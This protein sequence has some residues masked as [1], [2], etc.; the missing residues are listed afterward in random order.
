MDNPVKFLSEA[1]DGIQRGIDLSDSI[2]NNDMRE[3]LIAVKRQQLKAEDEVN[4]LMGENA[5]LKDQNIQL[6][7]ENGRYRVDTPIYD[8]DEG[9]VTKIER[10]EEGNTTI[11]REGV[12]CPKCISGETRRIIDLSP[13][14]I[15]RHR[16]G[17][18]C[19]S[20]GFMS[21]SAYETQAKAD[22]DQHQKNCREMAKAFDHR[23]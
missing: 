14:I 2:K 11:L 9:Y 12:F 18:Y 15:G 13:F 10:T 4:R 23:R 8:E 21:A 1:L 20:C 16:G 3:I 6:K 19:H 17:K 5:S 7:I 22:E